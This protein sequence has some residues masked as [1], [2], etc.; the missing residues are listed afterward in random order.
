MTTVNVLS[1]TKE[2]L[3]IL[4]QYYSKPN[5]QSGSKDRDKKGNILEMHVYT[6]SNVYFGVVQPDHLNKELNLN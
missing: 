6:E 3:R 5:I 1:P 2:P 4:S